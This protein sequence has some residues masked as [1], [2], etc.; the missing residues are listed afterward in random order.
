[1]LVDDDNDSYAWNRDNWIIFDDD[2]EIQ[3]YSAEDE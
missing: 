2:T 3:E 1:M